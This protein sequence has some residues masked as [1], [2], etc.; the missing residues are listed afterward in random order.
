MD[1]IIPIRVNSHLV[2][3]IDALVKEGT[4]RSRNDGIRDGIRFL[5]REYGPSYQEEKQ[6]LAQV[7][8]NFLFSMYPDTFLAV[9]LFG[10]VAKGRASSDSDIDLLTLTC[11]E[12]DYE[13]VGTFT[14]RLY[15]L[16]KKVP[17]IISLHF[18]SRQKFNQ[19]LQDQYTF[20][21]DIYREGILLAGTWDNF[22]EN[23][24]GTTGAK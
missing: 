20:E 4:F 16:L 13:A 6:I 8:A 11:Q 15:D 18:M 21:T 7:A 23:E 17:H 12:L 19:G 5:L 3:E 14:E 9:V 2:D 1:K 10:S 22:I 24:G